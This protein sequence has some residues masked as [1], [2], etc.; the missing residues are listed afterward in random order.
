MERPQPVGC[1]EMQILPDHTA[2]NKGDE[3]S[4]FVMY[5]AKSPEM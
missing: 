2:N 4:I 1:G 5:Y 3:A